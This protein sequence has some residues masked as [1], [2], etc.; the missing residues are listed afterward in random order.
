M[1]NLSGDVVTVDESK[2]HGHVEEVVRASVEETLNGLLSAEA[3]QLC[4]SI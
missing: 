4:S 2:I 1:G 3:Y